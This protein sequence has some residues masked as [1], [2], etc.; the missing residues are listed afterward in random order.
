[1]SLEAFKRIF[2]MEWAHR[3][4][5]RALGLIFFVPFAYFASRGYIRGKFLAKCLGLFALGG[6]QVFS[7][8]QRNQNL[9]LFSPKRAQLDGTW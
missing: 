1:M 8:P 9:T 3:E 4:L 5:G 6:A 2:W 7:T